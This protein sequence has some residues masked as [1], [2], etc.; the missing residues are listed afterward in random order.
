MQNIS[1]LKSF[2]KKNNK[3]KTSWRKQCAWKDIV[4]DADSKI[5]N[6][7]IGELDNEFNKL[8]KPKKEACCRYNIGDL[9]VGD[10][11]C[12]DLFLSPESDEKDAT[13]RRWCRK[14]L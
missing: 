11:D 10:H 14:I 13:N 2:S 6:E 4:S 7:N 3:S 5:L 1:T 8:A 9:F 12:G